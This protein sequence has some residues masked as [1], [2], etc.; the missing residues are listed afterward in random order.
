MQPFR[1]LSVWRKSHELTL[2]V[3]AATAPMLA[4]RNAAVAHLLRRTA[5]HVPCAVARAA[6]DGD[7]HRFTASL[8]AA[9]G[10]SRAL[11]Y[12]LLLARDLGELSS[13]EHATL[14]ARTDEVVRMLVALCRVVSERTRPG[15]VARGARGGR[16]QGAGT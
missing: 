15:R 2:R 1:R 12:H 4:G 5:Q 3:F 10:A 11:E 14:E 6:C 9:I 8:R 7:E 13:S 16:K